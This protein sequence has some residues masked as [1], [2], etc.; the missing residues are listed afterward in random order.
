MYE[1]F[2]D[3]LVSEP[4]PAR[5]KKPPARR[6]FRTDGSADAVLGTMTEFLGF[7]VQH[8]WVS[9]DFALMLSHPK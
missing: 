3:W 5:G 1:K 7:G 4:L 6:R 2:R 8:G 9:V